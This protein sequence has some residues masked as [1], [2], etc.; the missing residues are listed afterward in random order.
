MLKLPWRHQ[1]IQDARNVDYLLSKAANREWKQTKRIVL[2]STKMKGV[3]DLKSTLTT[4]M[5]IQSLELAQLV[6]CLF[7][8]VFVH[9]AILK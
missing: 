2:Q 9:Y 8:Q 7:L 1:D 4:D 3:G 6:S 5:M